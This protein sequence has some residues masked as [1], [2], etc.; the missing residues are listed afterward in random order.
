MTTGN[1]VLVHGLS[2]SGACK[3]FRAR[4]ARAFAEH[5]ERLGVRSY[6]CVVS[7]DKAMANRLLRFM[8][9]TAR[10][11]DAAEL[12]EVDAAALRDALGTD[13]GRAE[14]QRMASCAADGL[15]P[16]ACFTLLGTPRR[17]RAGR[18][19]GQRVLWF[20]RGQAHLTEAEFAAHY[21]LQHGPL[22]AGYAPL[23][24]LERYTHVVAAESELCETLRSL[25]LGRAPPP[26]VFAELVLAVPTLN[27]RSLH[28]RR[29]AM[30]AMH[31]MRA[32]KADEQ[33]HIDFAR[34]MLLLA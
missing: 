6:E 13:A 25:G 14:F 7:R 11:V 5:G 22:V 32:I 26:V 3:D 16:A 27:L 4:R 9:G 2:I 23:L 34:S 10:A 21:T 18:S 8:R 1:L 31:A 20:G 19:A 15:D 28:A 30:H 33:R 29:L 17:L 12:L 24:G